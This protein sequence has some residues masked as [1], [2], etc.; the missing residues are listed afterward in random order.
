VLDPIDVA[1]GPYLNRVLEAV[2]LGI[3]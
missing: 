2:Q 1:T 3:R